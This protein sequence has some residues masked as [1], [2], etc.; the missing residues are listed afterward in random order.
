MATHFACQFSLIAFAVAE[1]RGILLGGD[2]PA[3]TKLALLAGMLFFFLGLV[4]GELARRV[5]EESARSEFKKV[6]QQHDA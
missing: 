6:A 4:V 2:F 1:A 5:A 3:A